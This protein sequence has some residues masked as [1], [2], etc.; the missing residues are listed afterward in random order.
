MFTTRDQTDEKSPCPPR[1]NQPS[2][3]KTSIPGISN[4]GKPLPAENVAPS[5]KPTASVQALQ[6]FD[7]QLVHVA[8]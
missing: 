7:C 1:P 6:T 4:H 2:F 3:S 5:F 8:L